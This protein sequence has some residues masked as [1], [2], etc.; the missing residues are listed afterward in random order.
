[1]V[2]IRL[3][4]ALGRDYGRV[5]NLE[6]STVQEAVEAIS[7]ARKGFKQAIMKLDRMGMVFRV[8]SRDHDFDNDDVSTVLGS[9][10]RID[11]IPILR[12]ANA[13]VRFVIGALLVISTF[14][15]G[16][17]T[18][19]NTIAQAMGVSLMFGSVAEWLTPIPK[20]QDQGK[21]LDSWTYQGPV[22]SATNGQCVPLIFGE[23]LVGSVPISAGISTSRVTPDDSTDAAV[24]IGGRLDNSFY[25]MYTSPVSYK[26][27]YSAGI[28]NIADPLQ[29]TW[30]ISG[31]AAATQIRVSGANSATVE[32]TLTYTGNPGDTRTDTGTVGLSV[33]GMEST[34]DPPGPITRTA[35]VSPTVY[36]QWS[37]E[38][39]GS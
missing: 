26:L 2:E 34:G 35:S 10:E 1:M 18:F 3:H 24:T 27:V 31:F 21:S 23:V 6:I 15:P 37:Y 12:G 8:R 20:Q 30:T 29:F 38:Y 4:G 13:G 17:P 19:G 14:I 32:I 36:V 25:P 39:G 5:W 9:I 33:T 28:Y 22:N 7:R 11:I 16:S